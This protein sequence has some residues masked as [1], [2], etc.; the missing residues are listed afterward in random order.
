[1][2]DVESAPNA[3]TTANRVAPAALEARAIF[4]TNSKSTWRN[5]RDEHVIYRRERCRQ[6]R[7]VDLMNLQLF[8]GLDV[9]WCAAQEDMRGAAM[10]A[11][12]EQRQE[13]A[14]DEAGGAGEE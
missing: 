3:D 4:T 1:M 2:R 8:T 11:R 12:E 14:T 10:L 5:E 13:R 7:E 6:P 9:W